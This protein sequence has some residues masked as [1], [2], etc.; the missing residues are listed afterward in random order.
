MSCSAEPQ[1]V[2]ECLLCGTQFENGVADPGPQ[3]EPRCPQC[4]FFSAR[5][6]AASDVGEFVVTRRMPFR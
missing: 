3:G 6:V 5:P 2:Y 4:L 1:D